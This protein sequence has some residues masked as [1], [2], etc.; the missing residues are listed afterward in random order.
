MT[1]IPARELVSH[2]KWLSGVDQQTRMNRLEQQ[3][4]RLGTTV[5]HQQS[6]TNA[7]LPSNKTK[8]RFPNEDTLPCEYNIAVTP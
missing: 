6:R 5:H 2:F 1:E 3:F 7:T 4:T 8:N